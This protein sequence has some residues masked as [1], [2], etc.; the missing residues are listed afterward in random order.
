MVGGPQRSLVAGEV[1]E[2]GREDAADL[3]QRVRA[4]QHRPVVAGHHM[5]LDGAAHV[6]LPGPG[7]HRRVLFLR[8]GD[9]QQVSV[10]R[11]GPVVDGQM[12]VVRRDLGDRREPVLL[13]VG[14]HTALAAQDL[15]ALAKV[16]SSSSW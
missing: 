5:G 12:G 1:V 13:Q 3:G 9:Q 7:G 11:A 14:Q 15:P 4:G 10:D 16:I 6:R 8:A 2:L